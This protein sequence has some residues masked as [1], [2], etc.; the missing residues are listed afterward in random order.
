M[1]T[2]TVHKFTNEINVGRLEV[3]WHR[4]IDGELVGPTFTAHTDF[5]RKEF[6]SLYDQVSPTLAQ[7][8]RI[9]IENEERDQWQLF[10][11]DDIEIVMVHVQWYR[12]TNNYADRGQC[13]VWIR[14]KRLKAGGIPLKNWCD[15][16]ALYE[17]RGSPDVLTGSL[18]SGKRLLSGAE[19]KQ[20]QDN[21]FNMLGVVSQ[22]A[23][24][25]DE[26]ENW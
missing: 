6:P 18:N 16:Q 21:I 26:S 3:H 12:W 4:F 2:R 15:G 10:G 24:F 23:D 20:M 22:V 19:I 11:I 14:Y 1:I 25:L 13:G 9:I 5:H 7:T 8:A 17:I